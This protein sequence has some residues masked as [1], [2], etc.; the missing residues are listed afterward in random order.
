MNKSSSQKI[1][2]GVFVVLGTIVLVTSLYFIGNR[3]NLFGNNMTINAYFN[4]VNGL[5]LGNNVRYSGIVTGTVSKIEMTDKDLILVEMLIEEELSKK[6]KTNAVATIGTNGLV[7]ST[8][9]NIIPQDGDFPFLK[10]GDTINTYRKIGADDM[11]NTL[12]TTNENAALLMSDL[13]DITTQIRKGKGT[14]GMLVTD[15]LVA[16]DLRESIFQLKKT[17]RGASNTIAKLTAIISSIDLEESVAGVL[18]NDSIAA[19]KMSNVLTN[20]ER[21][22][23]SVDSITTNLNSYLGQITDGKGALNYVVNDEN[24]TKDIDSTMA[25]IKEATYRFNENMEAVKHNFLFRGYFKKLEKEQKKQDKLS[26][27]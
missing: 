26:K 14:I 7:G 11:L 13:L 16:Q 22:S 5:K 4:N 15:S 17:S 20:L 12:S 10:S 18:L 2:L 19:G 25:N 23:I 8:I 6:I 27:D 3:Q 21:S 1:G 9:V 24:L